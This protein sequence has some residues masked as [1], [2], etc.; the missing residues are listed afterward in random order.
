MSVLSDSA[1]AKRKVELAK[2]SLEVS[3]NAVTA[4]LNKR[5]TIVLKS[6]CESLTK[7]AEELRIAITKL[8]G[9]VDQTTLDRLETV[10]AQLDSIK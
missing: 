9:N 6:V 3:Q 4:D 1:D 8:A 7:I 2:A 5:N 10:Q